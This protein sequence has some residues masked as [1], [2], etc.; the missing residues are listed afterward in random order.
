M[1][2]Q[3]YPLLYPYSLYKGSPFALP[4]FLIKKLIVK[5]SLHFYFIFRLIWEARKEKKEF[6]VKKG[7][8]IRMFS[9][10]SLLSSSSRINSII[11]AEEKERRRRMLLIEF[12]FFKSFRIR[13]DCW[14]WQYF[15]KGDNDKDNDNI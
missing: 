10:L 8:I 12:R 14:G 2:F 13:L 6:R 3:L 1:K 5:N 4:P 11:A 7:T 9:A 15:L